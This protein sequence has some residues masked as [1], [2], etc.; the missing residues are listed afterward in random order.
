MNFRAGDI[1]IE[2]NGI[3]VAN[4]SALDAVIAAGPVSSA[5]VL[6]AGTVVELRAP[7][8]PASTAAPQ[9]VGLGVREQP[10]SGSAPGYLEVVTV[11][12]ML[13]A[14][15]LDLRVGDKL[16]EVNGKPVATTAGLAQ[17]ISMGP[18]VSAKVERN[19]QLL[20]LGGVVSF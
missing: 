7:Q 3:E 20:S 16:L 19:G 14:A 13:A 6:R 1:I 4:G 12:P 9:R 11:E 8:A 18:V 2:L 15:K 5:K 10:A 17:A